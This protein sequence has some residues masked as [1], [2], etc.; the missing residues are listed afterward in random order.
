MKPVNAIPTAN[1][2][3][4]LP[5]EKPNN[6]QKQGGK[7]P[8]RREHNKTISHTSH[9]QQITRTP[10]TMPRKGPTPRTGPTLPEGRV[11]WRGMILQG[12]YLHIYL[13]NGET[14]KCSTNRPNIWA[15]IRC[16]CVKGYLIDWHQN[17]SRLMSN[18]N[19]EFKIFVGNHT[20]HMLSVCTDTPAERM[21]RPW[22]IHLY[23]QPCT[24]TQ[25]N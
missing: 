7:N 2:G 11:G 19:G 14:L 18:N 6:P 15:L 22:L 25:I 3:T 4:H 21:R 13:D 1:P 16:I 10:K 9:K 20:V 24:P 23:G 8:N 5:G 17:P 12:G